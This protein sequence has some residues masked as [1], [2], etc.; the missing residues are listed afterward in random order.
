[1]TTGNALIYPPPNKY[2]LPDLY[3]FKER[4]RFFKIMAESATEKAARTRR[5]SNNLSP[6]SY[7][8]AKGF[9]RLS[10]SLKLQNII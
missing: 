9:E 7:E 10:T 3:K 4:P 1:M 2:L 5:S 6:C 8:T